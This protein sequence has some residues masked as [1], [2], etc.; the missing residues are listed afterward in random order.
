MLMVFKTPQDSLQN[1]R[2][3]SGLKASEVDRLLQVSGGT[4]EFYENVGLLFVPVSDLIKLAE[5]YGIDHWD[6]MKEVDS[7]TIW[8]RGL[9][10]P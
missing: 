8:Y 9:M 4:T 5:I 3:R 6:F 7:H 1:W 10:R 2:L